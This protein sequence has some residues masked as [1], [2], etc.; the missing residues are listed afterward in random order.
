MIRDGK[1]AMEILGAMEV[2]EQGDLASRMIPGNLVKGRG[3][4]MD[5]VAD[6]GRV[7]VVDLTSKHGESK[8]Q[9]SC[10]L[11]LTGKAVFDCI[12]THLGAQVVAENGLCL[13]ELAPGLSAKRM[14]GRRPRRR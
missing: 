6:V 9:K 2:S 12:I 4:A 3:G 5:L 14:C 13:V 10:N 8:V 7:V 1:I 11:P